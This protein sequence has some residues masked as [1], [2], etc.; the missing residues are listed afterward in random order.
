MAIH[1]G[2]GT[3]QSWNAVAERLAN[4]FEVFL[5]DRRGRGVSDP[6]VEPYSLEAE[7]ADAR[8]VLELAGPGAVVIGHS[9]GGAVALELARQTPR[10]AIAALILYEPA[11]GVG[12]LIPE[13]QIARI[14][15]LLDAGQP[16]QALQL[17]LE[18]LATHGLLP[19]N[20]PAA[21]NPSAALVDLAWTV[22]RELRAAAVLGPDLDRYQ[23]LAIP[24][25]VLTG[26]RSP[27]RQHDNAAALSQALPDARIETLAGQ[28]HVAHN[29]DPRHTAEVIESF[30]AMV[31]TRPVTA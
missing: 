3:A 21:A 15:A 6:G 9:F 28:G 13:S 7:V 1:G 26:D 4:A 27:R 18:Q 19:G 31:K 30:I 25:L 23:A 24:T 20:Q 10:D 14:S 17:G 8:A 11:A 2:L 12:H 16:A 5:L 29:S 22:P